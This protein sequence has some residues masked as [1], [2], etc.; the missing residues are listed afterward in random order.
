[1][2][3]AFTAKAKKRTLKNSKVLDPSQF[4]LELNADENDRAGSNTQ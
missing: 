2:K 4:I 3:D 1:M